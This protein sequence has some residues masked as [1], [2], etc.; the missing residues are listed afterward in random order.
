MDCKQAEEY[1]VDYL[2]GELAEPERE[3]F[4]HHLRACPAHAREVAQLLRTLELF[5]AQPQDEPSPQSSSR[6]LQA[7]REQVQLA[8]PARG[9]GLRWLWSP[10]AIAAISCLVLVAVGLYGYR[11]FQQDQESVLFEV[12]AGAERAAPAAP[13]EQ[14]RPLTAAHEPEQSGF[15]G[16]AAAPARAGLEE[17]APASRPPVRRAAKAKTEAAGKGRAAPAKSP[18]DKPLAGVKELAGPPLDRESALAESAKRAPGAARIG[19]TRIGAAG[20]AADDRDAKKDL[21]VREEGARDEGDM[22]AAAGEL[23]SRVAEPDLRPEDEALDRSA[24]RR[25]AVPPPAATADGIAA[26]PPPAREKA[27]QKAAVASEPSRARKKRSALKAAPTFDAAPETAVR[28]DAAD[29]P[30]RARALLAR[31]QYLQAASELRRFLARHPHDPRAATVRYELARVL[32]LAG[33]CREAIAAARQALRAAPGHALA[34]ETLLDQAS[35]H[36]K[37]GEFEPAIQ[38][39]RR[40]ERDFPGRAAE[41]R[42]A[43]ERLP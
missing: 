13:R 8:V 12:P 28:V 30:E 1:L 23:E 20:G 33:R 16:L 15:P 22:R 38:V 21:A 7:A 4:E 6:I 36:V 26:E 29:S 35:C 3:A 27:E 14:A 34:A 5:R 32:F 9:L 24:E 37:L 43:I 41:A 31:K 42:R 39:Y 17:P 25:F 11:S 2:Y 10:A 40:V 18:T 19:A